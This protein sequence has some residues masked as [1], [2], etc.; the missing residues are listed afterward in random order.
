MSII[1]TFQNRIIIKKSLRIGRP[2]YRVT[3]Q[4]D[5]NTNQRSLMFQIDYQEIEED[6]KPRYRFM[7]AYE[8]RKEPNDRKYQYILFHA[9][10]YEVIA[11]KMK[12]FEV[13]R[14][15]SRL[16]SCFLYANYQKFSF[17]ELYY[18][19]KFFAHWNP[20]IKEYTLQIYFKN[21]RER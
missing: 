3:K 6:C 13:D 9:E 7:S 5:A 20:D 2:G 19:E 14:N 10:P 12:S 16:D 18:K 11:F 17:Q 1:P 15:N 8:Q 4:F 21:P